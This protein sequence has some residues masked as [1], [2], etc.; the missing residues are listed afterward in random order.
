MHECKYTIHLL[1][2]GQTLLFLILVCCFHRIGRYMTFCN[3]ERVVFSL[4]AIRYGRLG[5]PLRRLSIGV[6][7]LDG[8]E[9]REIR[10]PTG[11]EPGC[12]AWNTLLFN[13][14]TV[15]SVL[16]SLLLV[17][18]S[19]LTAVY[20]G[21]QTVYGVATLFA[22]V[23]RLWVQ[24]EI[25]MTGH[26]TGP[27]MNST[28]TH[29][30]SRVIH[31]KSQ[32]LCWTYIERMFGDLALHIKLQSKL[33]V[34]GQGLPRLQEGVKDSLILRKQPD[35]FYILHTCNRRW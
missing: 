28:K 30:I 14:D 2:L 4:K 26:S 11:I 7:T 21:A 5:F 35:M 12:L 17:L 20:V 32:V 18:Y 6:A 19:L 31:W 3:S 22:V 16:Q 13:V 9:H 24:L 33:G 23:P 8:T 29:F 10:S 15:N 1:L 25:I 27:W 34:V